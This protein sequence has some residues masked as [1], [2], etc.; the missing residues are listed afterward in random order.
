MLADY[1]VANLLCGV[2]ANTA[3][4]YNGKGEMSVNKKELFL[5]LICVYKP[6]RC[7]AMLGAVIFYDGEFTYSK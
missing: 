2:A 4:F 5:N 7:G 1:S 6:Q 3:Y